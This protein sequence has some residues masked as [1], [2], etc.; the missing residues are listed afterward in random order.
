MDIFD[1]IYHQF[2]I[3]PEIYALRVRGLGVVLTGD[4]GF[5]TDGLVVQRREVVETVL[6]LQRVVLRGSRD[7]IMRGFT[8]CACKTGVVSGV[9]LI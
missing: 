2:L 4:S 7:V 8:F 1:N 9:D 6:C 5:G 3:S